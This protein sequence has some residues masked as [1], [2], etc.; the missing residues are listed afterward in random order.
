MLKSPKGTTTVST[1]LLPLDSIT[2]RLIR[3]TAIQQLA[4]ENV[5]ERERPIDEVD[6]QHEYEEDGRENF[7]S[8]RI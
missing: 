5:P 3:A 6:Q 8:R 4:L 1:I 2:C 7:E